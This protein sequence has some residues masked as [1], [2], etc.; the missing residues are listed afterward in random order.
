MINV[1]TI[2][3]IGSK[4]YQIGN[5]PVSPWLK[6]STYNKKRISQLEQKG[7]TP[8]QI[9]KMIDFEL[10]VAITVSFCVETEMVGF[11]TVSAEL[12][13][14]LLKKFKIKPAI[15]KSVI[16]AGSAFASY[17]LTILYAQHLSEEIFSM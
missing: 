15:I 2:I 1:G 14:M 11:A 8:A 10:G 13:A 4:I 16:I 6:K 17:W 3:N 9:E 7:Y 12:I 5:K